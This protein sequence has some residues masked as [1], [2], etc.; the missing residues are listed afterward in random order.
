MRLL[1]CLTF[2]SYRSVTQA[3]K[4]RL[5]ADLGQ[6]TIV[7]QAPLTRCVMYQSFIFTVLQV[8]PR[9]LVR[10]IGF[11]I[12]GLRFQAQLSQVSLIRLPFQV[13][14]PLLNLIRVCLVNCFYGF[15][16]NFTFYSSVSLA[17]IKVQSAR[18]RVLSIQSLTILRPFNQ[19]YRRQGLQVDCSILSLLTW[20]Q[21]YILN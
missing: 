13:I 4:D 14:R 20:C 17:S 12:T 16:K 18:N 19:V 7:I 9:E 21:Q 5:Q 1:S 15:T 11:T 10:S 8:S 3:A 2:S 6:Q